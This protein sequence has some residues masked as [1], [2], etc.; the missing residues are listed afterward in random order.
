MRYL[1]SE[2]LPGGPPDILCRV[3]GRRTMV[4]AFVCFVVAC[5]ARLIVAVERPIDDE[6]ATACFYAISLIGFLFGQPAMPPTAVRLIHPT[7][8]AKSKAISCFSAA[9]GFGAT[10]LRPEIRI[11]EILRNEIAWIQPLKV[12]SLE[13][14]R[15]VDPSAHRAAASSTNGMRTWI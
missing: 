5:T 10:G 6:L 11:L 4:V 15:G 2:A 3:S 8:F 1:A 9:A 13:D 7:G 14:E 12:H